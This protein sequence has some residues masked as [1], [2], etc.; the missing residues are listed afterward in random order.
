MF[1]YYDKLRLESNIYKFVKNTPITH[2]YNL[3]KLTNN[4]ILYKREDLQSIH[5]FKI[6]GA[7]LKINSL[8][9]NYKKKD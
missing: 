2:G 3:S 9:E 7:S 1:K 6:R 4:N 8:S 5:S